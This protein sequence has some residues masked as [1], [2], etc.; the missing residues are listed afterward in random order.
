MKNRKILV[1]GLLL[2]VNVF[3]TSCKKTYSCKCNTSY[4]ADDGTY[5]GEENEDPISIEAKSKAEATN[6]CH[7]YDQEETGITSTCSIN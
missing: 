3:F 2:A 7:T 4:Y 5:L 6:T 1:V